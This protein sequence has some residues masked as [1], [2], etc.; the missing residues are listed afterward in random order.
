M[1]QM[2]ERV[3]YV[4]V[5]ANPA[6]PGL[7]KIGRTSHNPE[8][9]AR[10]LSGT[11]A[12]AQPFNV[13][14]YRHFSDCVAAEAACH[15]L[16]E[17]RGLREN[18]RREFFRC[19]A[20]EAIDLIIALNDTPQS[21]LELTPNQGTDVGG[22]PAGH[23]FLLGTAQ[24]DGNDP[25]IYEDTDEGVKNLE[26][27]V[28]LGSLDAAVA[29]VSHHLLDYL[30][31]E[32]RR[33]KNKCLRLIEDVERKEPALAHALAINVFR[34]MGDWHNA[35]KAF[36]KLV[37][38]E[39]RDGPQ[40]YT[41]LMSV[42]DIVIAHGQKRFLSGWVFALEQHQEDFLRKL[43]ALNPEWSRSAVGLAFHRRFGK[44]EIAQAK[45]GIRYL[46]KFVP[47]A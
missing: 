23:Y 11:T 47:Q 22:D 40:L 1:T 34:S 26:I 10:E 46:D 38:C 20:K 43:F 13:V 42:V 25:A 24:L 3:G 6:M 30:A 14:Y 35:G 7:L 16:L 44:Q 4:Y 36:G 41:I 17:D 12:A 2:T 29:L 37:Q 19:D 9:R 21:S 15:R 18:N 39:V 28:S 33:A 5:L 8:G 27:A 32:N 31:C 45:A